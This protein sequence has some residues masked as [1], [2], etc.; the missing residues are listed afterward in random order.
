MVGVAILTD[1]GRDHAPD[2]RPRDGEADVL[3][4]LRDHTRDVAVEIDD[5][6]TAIAWVDGGVGPDRV[7]GVEV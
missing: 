3:A 6:P 7:C 5:R 4:D 1:P 2:Q